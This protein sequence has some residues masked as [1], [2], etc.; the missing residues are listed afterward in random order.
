MAGDLSLARRVQLAALSHIRHTM[1]RYDALLREGQKW[2]NAR[3]AVE[4]PCLDIIV[5]WRGDEET[6]RDQLDEILREVIEISD[7]EDS[8]DPSSEEEHILGPSGGRVRDSVPPSGHVV[9]TETRLVNEPAHAQSARREPSVVCL[10]SSTQPRKPTRKE[11]KAAK[12]TQQRFKR[13]AQVAEGFRHEPNVSAPSQNDPLGRNVPMPSQL[14]SAPEGERVLWPLYQQTQQSQ[15]F[16][17]PA[18][19]AS[20]LRGQSPVL[21]RIA[22]SNG[23]KVGQPPI[24]SSHYS[25]IPLSPVKHQYQDMLVPSIEPRSPGVQRTHGRMP[26][27]PEQ[28]SEPARIMRT[29]YEQPN[30]MAH[31]GSPFRSSGATGAVPHRQRLATQPGEHSDLFFGAGFIQVHREPERR[32]TTHEYM[33][34][35]PR[36]NVIPVTTE[37]FIRIRDP[38]VYVEEPARVDQGDASYRPRVNPVHIGEPAYQSRGGIA[39]RTRDHPILLDST[40]VVNRIVDTQNRM[41]VGQTLQRGSEVL[42]GAPL[43][44]MGSGPDRSNIIYVDDPTHRFVQVHERQ[45]LRRSRS[46]VFDPS[47]LHHTPTL[48]PPYYTEYIQSSRNPHPAGRL[49]EYRPEYRPDFQGRTDRHIPEPNHLPSQPT[50]QSV[51]PPVGYQNTHRT[52]P[53]TIHE[54]GREYI[55]VQ[56]SYS[57]PGDPPGGGNYY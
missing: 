55:P 39:L 40:P 2:E 38:A 54:A 11:R 19:G 43:R 41:D 48:M 42:H 6:G 46:P 37:P 17:E 9:A 53:V 45:P 34:K 33:N 12:Q 57:N 7:D 44:N 20:R 26:L 47:G 24:A 1:T 32:V 50:H 15:P 31:P 21:V 56:H 4:K 13:Y 23:S 3:K 51:Y 30:G 49:A 10:S 25:T 35:R 52:Q 28:G 29:I 16:V 22:V 18:D 36:S 27:Y 5:K 14:R 8:E